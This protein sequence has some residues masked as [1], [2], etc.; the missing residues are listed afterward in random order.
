MPKVPRVLLKDTKGRQELRVHKEH[1]ELKVLYKDILVSKVL[2]VPQEHKVHRERP[3]EP[4]DP[5][6]HKVLRV[7][8]EL[9]GR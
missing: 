5:L 4:K 3:K 7:P 2:R 8:Q 9:K 6:V 1:K